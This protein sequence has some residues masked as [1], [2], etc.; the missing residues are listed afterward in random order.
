MPE[1]VSKMTDG[2][3][4]KEEDIREED[5]LSESSFLPADQVELLTGFTKDPVVPNAQKEN[6]AWKI[7]QNY[8]NIGFMP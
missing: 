1:E 6:Y 3:N 8:M 4:F 5:S 2:E 7:L